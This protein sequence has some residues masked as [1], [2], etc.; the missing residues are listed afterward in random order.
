MIE[1]GKPVRK[2]IDFVVHVINDSRYQNE[3]VL[4]MKFIYNVKKYPGIDIT[5]FTQNEDDSLILTL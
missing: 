2:L 3:A 4:L 5:K 1:E